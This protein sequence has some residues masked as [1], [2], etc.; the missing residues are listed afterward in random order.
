MIIVAGT[1]QFETDDVSA[2]KPH[3]ISVMRETA[4]EQGCIC[5]RFCPDM[6]IDGLFQIY[7]EWETA[8]DLERHAMAPHLKSFV[9]ELSAFKLLDRKITMY[10]AKFLKSL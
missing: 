9:K 5:Y 3:I 8:E 6:Q 10:E 1:L 4:K 7:E 2:A